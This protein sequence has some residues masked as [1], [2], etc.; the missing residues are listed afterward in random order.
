[1]TDEVFRIGGRSITVT[2]ADKVLIPDGGITKRDLAAY[3]AAVAPAMVPH[4]RGRPLSVQRFPDG[5][6]RGGFMQKHTPP[7]VPTWVHHAEVDKVGGGTVDMYV[8]DNAA[9]LVY[10]ANQAGLTLHPWLSTVR[11][12]HKP[13]RL[14]FDLDP[15][16]DDE[17]ETVRMA[18]RTLHGILDELGL[19]SFPM[20][21]GSRGLHVTVPITPREDFD[22][23]RE[24][25][26]DVARELVA[27][28]PDDL[29]TEVRKTDRD[30]R[31]F[32]DTLRNAYGQHAVAPYSVRPLPGAP[33]ATP[34][35]WSEVDDHKVTARAYTLREIESRLAKIDGDPWDG[36]GRQA[37]SLAGARRRLARF[38]A[39]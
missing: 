24:F 7:A 3:Y 25:A 38:G 28:H 15:S 30:G 16:G 5:I 21:T 32:V 39:T 35:D 34:L 2:H 18:A 9:T 4:L 17:F 37:R 29:T 33:I 27:R 19:R 10:L 1:M 12:V 11:A 14:I 23:V 36:I 8:A 13:D 31:L 20:T 6:D 22:T 26:L